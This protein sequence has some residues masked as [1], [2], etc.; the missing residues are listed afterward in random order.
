[1]NKESWVCGFVFLA[2]MFVNAQDAHPVS[3]T[4]VESRAP[5]ESAPFVDLLRQAEAGDTHAQYS[6]A[7]AYV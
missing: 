5:R 3:S 4:N 6:V 2:A 1:M 7:D